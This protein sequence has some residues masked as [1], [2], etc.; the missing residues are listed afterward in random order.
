ME[1]ATFD[2]TGNERAVISAYPEEV[3]GAID[4]NGDAVVESANAMC[5]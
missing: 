2:S 1:Y 3:T 5:Q 4:E